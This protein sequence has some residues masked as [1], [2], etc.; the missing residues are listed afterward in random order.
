MCGFM[1]QFETLCLW[2]T[3][4]SRV[5]CEFLTEISRVYR[6]IYFKAHA[7]MFSIIVFLL[8]F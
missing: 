2:L 3:Q 1:F 4:D 6:I 7:I 8:L 5:P